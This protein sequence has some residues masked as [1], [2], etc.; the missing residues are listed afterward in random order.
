MTG[1]SARVCSAQGGAWQAEG[2][3]RESVGVAVRECA[4]SRGIG[5]AICSWLLERAFSEGATLAHLNPDTAAARSLYARL[6]F[7]ETVGFDI[8][9]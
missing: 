3:L 5:G 2:R 9:G 6:G 8:Y 1:L 7:A 4:R